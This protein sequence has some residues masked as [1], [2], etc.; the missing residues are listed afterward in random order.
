M[1]ITGAWLC[2]MSK[3]SALLVLG[4]VLVGVQMVLLASWVG[5]RPPRVL[6]SSS[7]A[8]ECAALVR[9]EDHYPLVYGYPVILGLFICGLSGISLKW[10]TNS[11]ATWNLLALTVTFV[12]WA[13]TA[14]V[15][16]L[17]TGM[18]YIVLGKKNPDLLST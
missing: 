9:V 13:V 6:C 8:L 12:T 1:T 4:L 16:S 15:E 18:Y 17:S 2:G 5:W 14:I 7:G 10:K 11:G 3:N